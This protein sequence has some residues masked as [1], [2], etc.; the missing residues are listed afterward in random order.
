MSDAWERDPEGPSEADLERFGDEYRTCP[1]CGSLVYDQ[2]EICQACGHAFGA[3]DG[4]LPIWVMIGGG[5]ALVAVLLV[6]LL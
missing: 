6:V 4:G 2:S 3:S 1:E 5:V